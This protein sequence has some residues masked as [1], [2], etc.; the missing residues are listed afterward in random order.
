MRKGQEDEVL[1]F[2]EQMSRGFKEK[3]KETKAKEEINNRIARPSTFKEVKVLQNS[4]HVKSKYTFKDAHGNIPHYQHLMEGEY[5]Q[6]K[7]LFA[8]ESEAVCDK[9]IIILT[10]VIEKKIYL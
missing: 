6:K 3:I 8:T 2:K 1:S 10:W 4:A 9:W 7:Y 5:Q